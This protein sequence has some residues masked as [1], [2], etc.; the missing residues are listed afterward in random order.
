MFVTHYQD[1]QF[2]KKASK[3]VC[4]NQ[5]ADRLIFF[6]LIAIVFSIEACGGGSNSGGSGGAKYSHHT[7]VTV[8][9]AASSI[10]AAQTL[11]VTV[12]VSGSSG[13]PTGSVILS[14]GSY[15]SSATPLARFGDDYD[16]RGIAG[17]RFRHVDRKVHSGQRQFRR[18]LKR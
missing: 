3:R 8:A 5:F 2:T 13:A 12:T 18:L 1:Y 9:P 14:S 10:K 15:A 4:M 6:S 17:S 11:A 16:S 7:S